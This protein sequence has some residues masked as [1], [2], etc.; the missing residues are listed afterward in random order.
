MRILGSDALPMQLLGEIAIS[1]GTRV[2]HLECHCPYHMWVLLDDCNYE[3]LEATASSCGVIVIVRRR[4]RLCT[5]DDE[6]IKLDQRV[7]VVYIG[8]CNTYPGPNFA[9]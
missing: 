1:G 9:R 6:T 4:S 5:N 2:L 8:P 3:I 7:M